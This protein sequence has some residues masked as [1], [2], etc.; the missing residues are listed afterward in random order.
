MILRS[1]LFALVVL[2]GMTIAPAA[3]LTDGQQQAL[4][5]KIQALRERLAL[6]P[7]QEQKIAPLLEA[8]NQKLRDLRAKYGDELSRS[9]KRAL[10]REGKA[11]QESFDA[12]LRPILTTE[13]MTEWQQ[14]R[15]EAR[16][17]AR[18]RYRNRQN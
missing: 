4:E 7:E 10:L 8:R 14:F 6:T 2:I 16:A 18:E 12:Q 9:D 15:D 13:Q 1:L 17:A 3:E 11:I 5:T